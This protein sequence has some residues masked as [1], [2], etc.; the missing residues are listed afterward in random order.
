M[1]DDDVTTTEEEPKKAPRTRAT[2]AKAEPA[3]EAASKPKRTPRA[4][5]MA[6][7]AVVAKERGTYRREPKPE[8]ELGRRK[9]RRG[10][11]VSSAG[12]KSITVRIDTARPHPK[13]HK[14]QRHSTRLHAHDDG[15]TAKVGDIVRI[16][17]TRPLSKLKRWRLIEIVEV[18]K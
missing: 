5:P 9:E 15:N 11:V 7:K 1:A 3:T 13:Y 14:I 8:H 2:R 12:D 10:V 6:K 16:V 18:A 17:E 4:K